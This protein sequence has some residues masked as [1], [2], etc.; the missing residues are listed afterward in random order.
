VLKT[1]LMERLPYSTSSSVHDEKEFHPEV[2]AEYC[3]FYFR[4]FLNGWKGA[5]Q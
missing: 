4:K 5:N 2:L 1:I 3:Q